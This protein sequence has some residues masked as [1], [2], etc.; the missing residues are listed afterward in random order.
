MKSLSYQRIYLSQEYLSSLGKVQ[1]RALFGGYSLAVEDVVFAMVSEGELYLRV[2]EESAPY[3]VKRQPPLLTYKKRGRDVSLNYYYV[4]ES[5]WQD[6]PLLVRLSSYS[7]N[8]ARS[9]IQHRK[10]MLRLK[11]LP[12]L[13][14]QLE[15]LLCEAGVRDAEMLRML[16]A[17][18]C[19]LRIKKMNKHLGIK[20][21]F[22]LE[23]AIFGLHEAALPTQR[24]Q[25]LIDWYNA[26]DS[27][28]WEH[29]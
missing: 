12:N 7:L 4:D 19:L 23:G 1:S 6:V 13:T 16:G 9:E 18:D 17:K 21:L 11:D 10:S 29:H 15:T 20:V 22:A 25:E 8:A 5:L 28:A 14:F 24:R 3:T 26:L 27:K 2:C